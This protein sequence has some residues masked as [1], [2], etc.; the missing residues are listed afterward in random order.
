MFS[1]WYTEDGAPSPRPSAKGPLPKAL[2]QRPSPKDP[3]PGPLPKGEGGWGV[4]VPFFLP[5][6]SFSPEGGLEAYSLLLDWPVTFTGRVGRPVYCTQ[7]RS[8]EYLEVVGDVRKV[9]AVI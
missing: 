6:V 7:V 3:H 4:Y 1:R 9:V 5:K 8:A 2:T